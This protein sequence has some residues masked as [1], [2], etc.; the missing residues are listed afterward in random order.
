MK[1]YHVV[2]RLKLKKDWA[3]FPKG[4]I[5]DVKRGC[6]EEM[7]C[8]PT[9]GEIM[10]NGQPANGM[11]PRTWTEYLRH[12]DH[13]GGLGE[14]FEEFN[15]DA[16]HLDFMYGRLLNHGENENYDYMIRFKEIIGTFRTPKK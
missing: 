11:I 15:E 1:D 10:P 2:K 7:L 5:F 9:F 16:D 13:V 14:W 8:S 4:T 6:V 3:P 12:F